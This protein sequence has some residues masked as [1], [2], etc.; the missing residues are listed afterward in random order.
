MTRATRGHTGHDLSA[1]K[2]TVVIYATIIVAALLR[3]G[4]GAFPQF[5]MGLLELAGAAWIAAFATFLFE[6][7]PM[8]LSPR[9]ERSAPG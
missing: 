6:Y 2:L 8:L 5:Y 9:V 4:A 1:S 3:I 7:A